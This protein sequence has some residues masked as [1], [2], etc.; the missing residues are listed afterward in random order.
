MT[1]IAVAGIKDPVRPE[2]SDAVKSCQEAGI[3]VRLATGADPETAK[4]LARECGILQE[5]GIVVKGNDYRAMSEEQRIA[6]TPN[7]CHGILIGRR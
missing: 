5:G 4:S 2:V 7:I 1:L 3:V 6:V